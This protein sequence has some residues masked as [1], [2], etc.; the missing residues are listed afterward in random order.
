LQAVFE[1]LVRLQP[2]P[3]IFKFANG[4][5]LLEIRQPALQEYLEVFMEMSHY[6]GG[7]TRVSTALLTA[8]QKITEAAAP[9]YFQELQNLLKEITPAL[10]SKSMMAFPV[11]REQ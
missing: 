11:V 10:A 2:Q 3:S 6:T 7:N 1:R 9:L 4:A 5:S 8:L